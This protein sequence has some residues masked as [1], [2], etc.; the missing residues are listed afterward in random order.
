MYI[1]TVTQ[2]VVFL[3]I[4]V[5]NLGNA[6]CWKTPTVA[7]SAAQPCTEEKNTEFWSIMTPLSDI[8]TAYEQD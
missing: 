3:G 7:S 2:F 8:L 1:Q 4:A 6:V 5:H